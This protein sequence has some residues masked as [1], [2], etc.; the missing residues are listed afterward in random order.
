MGARHQDGKGDTKSI[1]HRNKKYRGN[2]YD[3]ISGNGGKSSIYARDDLIM[4]ELKR[5]RTRP[6]A[7]K[8]LPTVLAASKE[9]AERYH[10]A[11]L[12]NYKKGRAPYS[13]EAHHLIPVKTFNR[14][15]FTAKQRK[16][17]HRVPSYDINNGNNIIFLPE[18]AAD[19]NFHNLPMHRGDHPKY[20]ALVRE[21]AEDISTKLQKV[22]DKDPKH[23]NW[24][25]PGDIKTKLTTLQNKYWNY[26]KNAGMISVNKFQRPAIKKVLGKA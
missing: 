14:K 7:N 25:P 10:F 19:A 15:P 22:I 20:T 3:T 18:L 23:K 11:F 17:L 24:D 21:D 4:A 16:V 13:N 5:R 2:G 9:H 8:V 26:L 12:N 6:A 1:F